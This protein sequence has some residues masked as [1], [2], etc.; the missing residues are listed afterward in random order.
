MILLFQV[1]RHPDG[2]AKISPP[3]E[4]GPPSMEQAFRRRCYLNCIT[5]QWLVDKLWKAERKRLRKAGVFPNG[6]SAR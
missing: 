3:E 4:P 5:D 1:D 6:R 2:T